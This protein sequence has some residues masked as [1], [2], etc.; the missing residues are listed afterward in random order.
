MSELPEQVFNDLYSLE[1]LNLRLNELTSLKMIHGR[2]LKNLKSL[3]ISQNKIKDLG[4][5]FQS[6]EQLEKIVLFGNGIKSLKTGVF[7]HLK[8][9]FR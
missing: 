4:K 7:N 1:T 5:V 3:D 8:R 9:L 6:F 2:Y